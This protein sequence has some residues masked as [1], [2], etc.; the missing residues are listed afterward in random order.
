MNPQP[1]PQTGPATAL[2]QLL[3]ENPDLP[4]IDWSLSKDGQLHGYISG[5]ADTVA[6]F[7]AYERVLGGGSGAVGYEFR[8]AQRVHHYL[9]TTWRDVALSIDVICTAPEGIDASGQRPDGRAAA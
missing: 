9:H 8:G 3:A 2:A 7:T 5:P 6:V 1:S 4:H